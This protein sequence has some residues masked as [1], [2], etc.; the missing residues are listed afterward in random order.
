M[1]PSAAQIHRRTLG[2][3]SGLVLTPDLFATHAND[4]NDYGAQIGL[5]SAASF[6]GATTAPSSP[7]L[8]SSYTVNKPSGVVV[9]DLIVVSVMIADGSVSSAPGDLTLSH[10]EGSTRWQWYVYTKIASGTDPSSWT[11]TLSASWYTSLVASVYRGSSGIGPI[12]WVGGAAQVGVDPGNSPIEAPP[13]TSPTGSRVVAMF[14]SGIFSNTGDT[15]FP[16]GSVTQRVQA[17]NTYSNQ[18]WTDFTA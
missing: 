8:A 13:I 5:G 10:F 9:G 18:S 17:N 14:C 4:N 12:N 11:F 2:A 1:S 6:I 15:I 7:S 16:P 3:P